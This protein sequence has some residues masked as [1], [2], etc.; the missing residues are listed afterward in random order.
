MASEWTVGK[1]KEFNVDFD[2]ADKDKNGTLRF[3]E[4]VDL[5]SKNGY[6]G[7]YGQTKR[8]F[9]ELDLDNDHVISRKEFEEAMKKIP[10][11][12]VKEMGMRKMFNAIDKDASGFLTMKELNKAIQD[13]ALDVDTEKISNILIHQCQTAEKIDYE[14][15]LDLYINQ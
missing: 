9:T 3:K 6:R 4:I 12:K 13:I 5:L 10:D 11:K 1:L 2:E 14:K 8:L 15:F 7:D